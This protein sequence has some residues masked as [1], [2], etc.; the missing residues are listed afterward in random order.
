[1]WWLSMTAN[2][3]GTNVYS[4]MLYQTQGPPFNAP[5]NPAAVSYTAGG[6]G[7][8]TFSDANN[9]TFAYTV[10]GITQTNSLTRM[11]V[12][13]LPN[14]T[15]AMQTNLATATNYQD[16]WWDSG[17]TGESGWGVHFTHQGDLIFAT[18]FTYDLNGA[19]LWLSATTSKTSAGVYSGAL[20]RTT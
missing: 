3:T 14:C 1:P 19:P 5:F 6:T 4:G 18:W 7:T 8:L 15:P 9:T 11:L 16:I 12:G 10:N 20:I 17:G 13:T 2:R